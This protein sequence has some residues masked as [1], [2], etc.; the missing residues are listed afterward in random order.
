MKLRVKQGSVKFNDTVY[1]EGQTFEIDEVQGKSLLNAGVVEEVQEV[2]QEEKPKK[3]KKEKTKEEVK[4]EP[5]NE[6]PVEEAPV[7]E[8]IEPSL[9]WTRKELIV[10]AVS[11]GIEDTDKLNSK[12]KILKAIQAKEEVKPE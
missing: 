7:D 4:E 2:A 5:V 1:T 11:L 10:H 9:D 3:D 12:E 8:V 6:E